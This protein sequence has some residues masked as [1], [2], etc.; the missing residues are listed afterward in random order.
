[1]IFRYKEELKFGVPAV[2]SSQELR[3]PHQE[4]HLGPLLDL[5]CIMYLPRERS[6]RALGEDDDGL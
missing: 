1:M 5:Y 2:H 4:A 6:P 3:E